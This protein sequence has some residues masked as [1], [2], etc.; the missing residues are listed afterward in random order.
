MRI[1][2]LFSEFQFQVWLYG[3]PKHRLRKCQTSE[4]NIPK[5]VVTN[6]RAVN[7]RY[8]E[9]KSVYWK[10][11]IRMEII[12]SMA[13]PRGTMCSALHGYAE[14]SIGCNRLIHCPVSIDCLKRTKKW[15]K[16]ICRKFGTFFNC[17]TRCTRSKLNM[18]FLCIYCAHRFVG[19]WNVLS[20]QQSIKAARNWLN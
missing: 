1:N 19:S 17:H 5:S 6:V 7:R 11:F 4:L 10:W 12:S 15:S 2:F 20:F 8:D 9:L 16:I 18:I 3:K 14:N 13:K